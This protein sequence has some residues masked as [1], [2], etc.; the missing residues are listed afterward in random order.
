MKKITVGILCF[1]SFFVL[2]ACGNQQV[3][4]SA[5][6]GTSAKEITV[7]AAEGEAKVPLD[8]QKVVVF[9]NSALDTMDALGVGDRVIGAATANLPEYLKEYDKVESAGGIKEP[10]LE[11]INQMKPDLIIISGR[12]RDFEKEL[13]AIAPTLFLSVDTTRTWGSIQENITTLGKIFE[14]EKDAEEKIAALSE[15]IT[16][17]KEQAEESQQKAL[18]V[19]ANEGNLS[20]Y[21]P[22][23]RFSIIHDTFGFLPADE[24][25]EA[26][27]H[28][29]SISYEYILEKN[30]DILFVID[31][32]KA[33]GGDDSKNQ[34]ADNALVQQTTAGKNNQV[35]SL[36]P[37]VWYLAGSGLESLEI[38]L[39]NVSQALK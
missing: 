39:D 36:D 6:E 21:G 29:Q 17:V 1:V 2:T 3:A 19:L 15:K 8:P 34:V 5:E 30:P 37:Q 32:T 11:K 10:D 28:G 12:Q 26:S 20:A 16:A 31:R 18:V 14:K 9:D 25:I 23:S 27:T 24:T 35:I 13:S 33:V 4:T 22:G 38:M 7:T